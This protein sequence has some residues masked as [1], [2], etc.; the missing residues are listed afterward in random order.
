MSI[1]F[2]NDKK[3]LS[4]EDSAFFYKLRTTNFREK[5]AFHD[6]KSLRA[7]APCGIMESSGSPFGRPL[8]DCGIKRGA[9]WASPAG[10]WN[11]A[12]RPLGVPYG[13]VE[14]SGAPSGRP[15]REK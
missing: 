7:T 12:G 15:L 8:R 3:A 14:S 11:Q 1:A 2:G 6:G 9:L 4:H 10:L 13:I 5:G